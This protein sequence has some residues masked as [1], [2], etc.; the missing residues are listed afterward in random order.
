MN[1]GRA[2]ML[3]FA[4][5]LAAAGF[6]VMG[7]PASA[8][9]SYAQTATTTQG[10]PAT[11][12]A[13]TP[14]PFEQL[15]LD[16]PAAALGGSWTV[17][18]PPG[19]GASNPPASEQATATLTAAPDQSGLF[20][21]TWSAGPVQV[22]LSGPVLV[23]A[24]GQLQL[25]LQSTMAV[26]TDTATLTGYG[27]AFS[28]QAQVGG[29]GP[30]G[31]TGAVQLTLDGTGLTAVCVATVQD[32]SP[33]LSPAPAVPPA[34]GGVLGLDWRP[35]LDLPQQAVTGT[36][37]S[38]VNVVVQAKQPFDVD[39]TSGG[40]LS[41]SVTI[42]D[43]GILSLTQGQLTVTFSP[44]TV[45]HKPSQATLTEPSVPTVPGD[46]KITLHP[47]SAQVPN[48]LPVPPGVAADGS[49]INGMNSVAWSGNPGP[50]SGGTPGQASGW[51]G[52]SPAHVV[53]G[54][55]HLFF[56][57]N[58]EYIASTTSLVPPKGFVG[59]PA[60]E[61]D[62][63]EGVLY[64]EPAGTAVT[65][66]GPFRIYFNHE[67]RTGMAK[68]GCVVVYNPGKGPV[69]FTQ[70]ATGYGGVPNNP[71]QTGKRALD[72]WEAQ[73]RAPKPRTTAVK[74]GAA[75]AFCLPP[76][77]PHGGVMNA[78]IDA[79]ATGRSTSGPSW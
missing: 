10:P 51:G 58:P 19:C 20:S 23:T 5:P 78:I 70:G 59:P 71:V 2:R 9:V 47:S 49:L 48:P 16:Q 62:V 22:S 42:E 76:I 15:R 66:G 21:L 63:I 55:G 18:G 25:D 61:G 75:Y 52:T 32:A 65:S 31:F 67:N 73:R 45:L 13:P 28:G 79:H 41:F 77:A 33:S 54:G 27:T 64:K 46:R 39:A 60:P 12:A 69:S 8:P 1:K 3:A 68:S 74:P 17:T 56:S 72:M 34:A 7:L 4:L 29:A 35:A 26:G 37:S 57:D 30:C 40:K 53:L 14:V 43:H 6:A 38:C 44:G 24:Q 11:S 36:A 50:E